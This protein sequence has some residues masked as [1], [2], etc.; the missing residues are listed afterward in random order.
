MG[1]ETFYVQFVPLVIIGCVFVVRMLGD[2]VLVRQEGSNTS[3]L[4]DAFAS[5][6][7]CQ[8]ILAHQILTQLLIVQTV[9]YLTATAFASVEGVDRLF[10]K[11]CGQFL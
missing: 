4:Q 8:F 9:G 6:H 1:Q 2:I 10:T 5:V 3:K 11:G 7:N